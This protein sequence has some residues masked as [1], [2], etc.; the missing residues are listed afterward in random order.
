MKRTI[1]IIHPGALGDVL[2][3]VPAMCRLRDR[4]PHHR[5]VLCAGPDISPFL[6]ACNIVD[7]WT[8]VE[9]RGVSALFAASSQLESRWQAWLLDCDL[10]VAW[11]QDKDGRIADNL[12]ASGARQV[13]VRSPFSQDL[14]AVHQA[15][16]FLEILGDD[17][18]ASA[19]GLPG[20]VLSVLSQPG[21]K[22]LE[23]RGLSHKSSLVVIHPGSGSRT[24]CVG[25]KLLISI[26]EA[27]KDMGATPLI[28]EGPADQVQ[29]ET[30]HRALADHPPVVR[31]IDLITVAGLI[32]ESAVYIGHDSGLTHLA[33]L[34]GT[35]TVA[36]FGPTNPA[37]WAPRGAHVTV[38]NGG[39]SFAFEESQV[40][41]ACLAHLN[42]AVLVERFRMRLLVP[43]PAP[44]LQ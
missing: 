21:K 41:S 30:L 4:F 6:A 22:L 5:L 1:V 44:M 10:A 27:V 2:L 34:V 29:V 23:R 26:I 25:P 33:A 19:E 7:A 35:L 3:A 43:L 16:R 39:T 15:D 12:T 42:N 18:V 11:M 32:A 17:P 20:S 28:V 36:L 13:I 40:L 24:K 37:R 9:E 31:G 14:R 8:S 38:V